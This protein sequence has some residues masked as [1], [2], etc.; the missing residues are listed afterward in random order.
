[1]ILMLS[2]SHFAPKR[3]WPFNTYCCREKT[4]LQQDTQ[5]SKVPR[6][7]DT[8]DL[9]KLVPLK[10]GEFI[11]ANTGSEVCG[12]DWWIRSFAEL[13]KKYAD[14]SYFADIE[15]TGFDGGAAHM[16]SRD[17]ARMSYCWEIVYPLSQEQ[18]MYLFDTDENGGNAH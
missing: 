1:M 5:E 16:F 11:V 3:V 18:Y 6:R 13:Q 10:P 9:L 15:H 2:C 17:P 7:G 8:V 12:V 14:K 4:T